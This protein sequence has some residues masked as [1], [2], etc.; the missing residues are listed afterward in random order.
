MALLKILTYP[1]P[2]L[3]KKAEPLT[4]FGPAQQKFFDDMIKTMHVEDGVGLAAPQVGVSKRVLIACPNAKPGE[5]HVIVNPEILESS[6]REEGLEGCLSVPG[7]SGKVSRAKK[8]KLRYKDRHGNTHTEE[9]KDFY[10]R[11]IQHEIDHLDGILLIDRVDF[12][13][14]QEILSQYQVL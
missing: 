14:R 12:N 9:I 11:V 13:Q 6:G 1:N 3:K 4:D 2:I 10:A 7:I 8:I 5:E